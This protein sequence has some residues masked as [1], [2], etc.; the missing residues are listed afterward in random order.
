MAEAVREVADATGRRM[1]AD[2]AAD[3]DDPERTADVLGRHGYE[4]RTSDGEVC[5]ANC[6]FDR[7][8]AQH[9]EPVCG[10]NPCAHRRCG[11]R[12]RHAGRTGARTGARVLLREDPGRAAG[13]LT[14]CGGVQGGRG[15][16]TPP[17]PRGV[18]GA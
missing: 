3:G 9:T 8:A 18:A 10:M 17:F 2:G 7:L 16:H 6:P 5:L 14:R 1:A 4:P 13:S 12:P 15:R 11:R